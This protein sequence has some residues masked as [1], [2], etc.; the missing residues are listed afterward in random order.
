MQKIENV[1][2]SDINKANH[3]CYRYGQYLQHYWILEMKIPVLDVK[4]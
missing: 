3:W 2:R 4:V 1:E